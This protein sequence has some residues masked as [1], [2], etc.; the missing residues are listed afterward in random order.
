[1]AHFAKLNE[2]NTVLEVICVHNN[3]LLDE[4]GIE[5]EQKGIDFLIEWSGGHP[6]WKQTSYNGSFRK[7]FAGLMYTY[8][9]ELDAF[10]PPRPFVHWLFDNVNLDWKP[11][12][13]RPQDE[14]IYIWNDV[15]I[16][17]DKVMT[18]V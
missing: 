1:M 6:Y 8:N 16:R 14:N 5:S 9:P 2:H 10:I 7:R 18:N 13:E 12:I 17:W 11:P 15:D 4:N 3:E